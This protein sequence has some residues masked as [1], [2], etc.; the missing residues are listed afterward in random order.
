M[1]STGRE[2]PTFFG[3]ETVD[4]MCW[5]GFRTWPSTVKGTCEGSIWFGELSSDEPGMD[6]A[7]RH[8]EKDAEWVWD[9]TR[10]VSGGRLVKFPPGE[11]YVDPRCHDNQGFQESCPALTTRAEDMPCDGDISEALPHFQ[12]QGATIMSLCCTLACSTLCGDHELCIRERPQATETATT[13]TVSLNLGKES[14]VSSGSMDVTG[15]G[16]HATLFATLLSLGHS[17][18]GSN[19]H[20]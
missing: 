4:E 6:I 19:I 3:E 14:Q 9:G 1:D 17:L 8:P 11:S 12:L 10:L 20:F 7:L 5:A 2:T 15:S 16:Y 18:A 13:T